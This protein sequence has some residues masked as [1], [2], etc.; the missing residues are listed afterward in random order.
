MINLTK[1]NLDNAADV[2]SRAFYKD[3]L[4]N[5]FFPE[6]NTRRQLSFYTF[7]FIVSHTL[8]RGFVVATSE[9]FEGAAIWLPSERIQRGLI[10]QIRFGA[11]T[12]LIRQGKKRIDRQMKASHHMQSIHRDLIALPHI[13]LSTIGIDEPHRGKRLASILMQPGLDMADRKKLPCYLDTHNEINIGIY[14]RFGFKVVHESIIPD[15]S[16]RHWSM[17]RYR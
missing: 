2:L 12:T 4:F 8:A 16:V 14:E 6:E 13:Y 11:L 7:R 5:Y 15:S 17:I 9:A 10:D 1:K 3:P